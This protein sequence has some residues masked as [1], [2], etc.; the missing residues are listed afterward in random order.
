MKLMNAI[1]KAIQALEK[2]DAL[3]L[4]LDWAIECDFG[5][6]NLGEDYELYKDQLTE[7]MSY[8]DMM[9]KIAQCHIDNEQGVDE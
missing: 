1:G 2:I 3:E 5:L 9:I 7:D 4:L 8:K 6:D